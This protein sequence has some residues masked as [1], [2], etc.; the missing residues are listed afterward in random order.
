VLRE[1]KLALKKS[2]CSFGEESVAYLDHIIST[3][4]VAMGPVKVV[5]VEAWSWP[6]SL[7]ALCG[8]LGLTGHYHK[9]IAS[10]GEVAAPLTTLLKCEAFKWSG[11][12]EA[13]FI[14]LKH[15][16]MTQLLQMPDFTKHFMVD[17]VTFGVSFGTVLHQGDGAIAFFS[18]PVAPHHQK[19]PTYEWELI[20]LVKVVHN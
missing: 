18:R 15:L 8:F 2:K 20:G 17:C 3:V 10:N 13:T 14:L 6:R 19:L 16:M 5:V 4:G 12:T 11:T 9:F 1:H 7:Q